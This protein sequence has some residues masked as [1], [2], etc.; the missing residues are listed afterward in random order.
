MNVLDLAG[1]DIQNEEG[2]VKAVSRVTEQL[3]QSPVVFVGATDQDIRTLLEAG[4]KCAGQDLVLA[5]ALAE[6]LRTFHI[7]LA[8][9][10]TS[11]DVWKEDRSMLSSLFEELSDLL[12][13]LY[14]L[15]ELTAHGESVLSSYA[16]RANAVLISHALKEKGMQGL[17]FT[18]REVWLAGASGNPDTSLK[19]Q[20][21]GALQTGAI[22]VVPATLRA[23]VTG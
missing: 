23:S 7:Q 4:K 18:S 22:P 14:I 11:R 5:S 19:Q 15:G 17:A 6:G 21:E 9:Q 1:S 8:Q 16:E 12:K 13:G 20:V 10:V 2:V 3:D